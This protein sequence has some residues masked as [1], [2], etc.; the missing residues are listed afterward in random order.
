MRRLPPQQIEKNLSDLI[1]LVREKDRERRVPF[2]SE[3][4]PVLFT[5][6][7]KACEMFT[8]EQVVPYLCAHTF[9]T[10]VGRLVYLYSLNELNTTSIDIQQHDPLNEVPLG[11][12][13]VEQ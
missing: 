6:V 10:L 13:H 5:V 11:Y 9:D 3:M 1:D 2:H 4:H 7:Q 8:P 12:I